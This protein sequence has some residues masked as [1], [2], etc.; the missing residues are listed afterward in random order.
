MAN[1]AHLNK[2]I[3]NIYFYIMLK[4]LLFIFALTASLSAASAQIHKWGEV[5]KLTVEGNHLVD[6]EGNQVML[7]G[8]MDTPSPYFSG[9]RF[10][11]GHWIDVYNQG[12]QYVTKA[13]NYFDQLFTAVTDTAQGSWCNVFRLHLDP[14]WTDN[15]NVS[16]S[17]FTTK[18]VNGQNKTYDPNGTEVSGEGNI[19]RFDKNRLTKYMKSLFVPI[20][21]KAKGHGMYV[22]M[23]PPGVCP[24]TIKVGDYYQKYLLT[25]WDIVTKNQEV[26]DNSDWLSIELANEP[27]NI[28]DANGNNTNSAMHDFF[29]PIVDKIRENGFKGI[30]WVPGGTWQQDYRPYAKRPIIDPMQNEDGTSAQ[31]IGY[32]VH[33]YPGWFSASDSQTD[34]NKSIAAFL[35]GVPVVK[36]SPIMITEV[37][38]SPEQ[39]PKVFDH[40]NEYGQPV[41]KNCGTWATGS[42]S[43]FG[44]CF[45]AVI[46]YYGNIGWTLTHTHDYLDIDYYR[47]TQK[48]RPAFTDKLSNNAY[49][50]C[51]GAC[52]VWYPQYASRK[53][54]AREWEVIPPSEIEPKEEQTGDAD[55]LNGKTLFAT[56]IDCEAIWYVNEGTNDP[57]NVKVGDYGDI[58]GNPFCWLKFNK[59]SNPGCKT[60]G[61][62]YTIQM[63]NELGSN[64]SLWGSQGYLNTP[65]G[66]WCLFALGID[67][68]KY[69]TDADYCG[70]WQ[71]SYE[72]GYG[73][74]IR[75]VGTMESNGNSYITPVAGTPQGGKCYVRLFNKIGKRSNTS[76]NAIT[77]APAVNDVYYDILGQR[78]NTPQKGQLY[79]RNGHKVIVR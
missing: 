40:N 72:E 63:A 26:L 34:P 57:Q 24:Q 77:A 12:D 48:V 75:N 68:H 66:A 62:L 27:I 25:V 38:W 71:V 17:G 60:T 65:P 23:R 35:D 9:Y 49:E 51:S 76:V 14:C 55:K 42:T 32:A 3:T 41:Y 52:F 70:L 44:K 47:S 10:T 29:Q 74:V 33:F 73:Y 31:Q 36:T 50:A 4:K 64:Y 58:A 21:K 67:N 54:E 8:V 5:S 22:I 1:F 53:H 39:E 61:N 6:P 15:P 18:N 56:D 78:V 20:A 13:I 30:I 79:I 11:D 46:D 45:R 59:V 69:G 43:K 28:R 37:D 16:A 2:P 19:Q 7:H